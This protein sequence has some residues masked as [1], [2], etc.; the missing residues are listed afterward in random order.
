MTKSEQSTKDFN[1]TIIGIR[2][3]YFLNM[4]LANIFPSLT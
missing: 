2:N 3:S 1:K 4:I